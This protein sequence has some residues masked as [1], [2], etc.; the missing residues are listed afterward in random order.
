MRSLLIAQ[1]H[2]VQPQAPVYAALAVTCITGA[3]LLRDMAAF[4]ASPLILSASIDTSVSTKTKI[5]QT[6]IDIAALAQQNLFGVAVAEQIIDPA[7]LAPTPINL[8][9]TGII[10][11]ADS[12]AS[13]CLIAEEAKPAQAYFVGDNL[14]GQIILRRVEATY[15]VL[16]RGEL[17]EKL[18][19][20]ETKTQSP[21]PQKSALPVAAKTTGQSLPKIIVGNPSLAQPITAAIP[22]Q[23]IHKELDE[24]IA[25]IREAEISTRK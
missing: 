15:V 16:Q 9:L 22:R 5:A 17:L 2:R 24:R 4:T 12:D 25:A 8:K 11:S 14:P 3:L 23:T 19:L 1:W 6:S 20:H 7:K 10:T 13:R 18:A 21:R